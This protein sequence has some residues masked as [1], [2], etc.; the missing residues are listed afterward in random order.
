[1]NVVRIDML[2]ASSAERRT[3]ITAMPTSAV[4]DY[5]I[6]ATAMASITFRALPRRFILAIF[7]DRH[8]VGVRDVGLIMVLMFSATI[9]AFI[10]RHASDAIV[11]A[12]V[13]V[14]IDNPSYSSVPPGFVA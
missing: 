3:L 9:R 12:L 1:M 7:A 8:I 11:T 13:A 14:L 2:F 4:Y 10:W 5:A 6:I